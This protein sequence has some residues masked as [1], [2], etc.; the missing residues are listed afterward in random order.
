MVSAYL[1]NHPL[2]ACI[3]FIVIGVILGWILT[4]LVIE[5]YTDVGKR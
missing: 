2:V 5:M 3:V 1:F 4:S